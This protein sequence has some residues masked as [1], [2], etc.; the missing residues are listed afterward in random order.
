[1][2]FFNCRKLVKKTSTSFNG[3]LNA[4]KLKNIN[5]RLV[6]ERGFAVRALDNISSL[7]LF[8]LINLNPVYVGLVD[9]KSNHVAG[10]SGEE[11][12]DLSVF[13]VAC[14]KQLEN[15]N[16]IVDLGRL[17]NKSINSA[18]KVIKK[19]VIITDVVLSSFVDDDALDPLVED[20]LVAMNSLMVIEVN[21]FKLSSL[22]EAIIK[23]VNKFGSKNLALS[24][25]NNNKSKIKKLKH[26]LH[27]R[28]VSDCDMLNIFFV[29]AN[30]FLDF[31]LRVID[32][33]REIFID[34]RAGL[35]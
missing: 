15:F 25:K 22:V 21:N 12:T 33:S 17:N 10:R 9:T 34:K 13:G 23:F 2:E 3:Y 1:M 24:S 29:N 32:K 19:P 16:C 27:K 35:W 6:T 18:I 20:R 7:G 26:L 14:I 8:A 31:N 28:G 4:V 11:K 30:K 5:S